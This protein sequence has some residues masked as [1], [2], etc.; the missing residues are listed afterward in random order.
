MEIFGG[1][2]MRS[3][4]SPWVSFKAEVK[5]GKT[6]LFSCLKLIYG[7]LIFALQIKN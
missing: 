3:R 2:Y 7:F 1:L 5:T 4:L 6:G